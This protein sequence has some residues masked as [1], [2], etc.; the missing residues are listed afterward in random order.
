MRKNKEVYFNETRAYRSCNPLNI[1]WSATTHWQGQTGKDEKGFCQFCGFSFGYQAAV[2]IIRSYRRRHIKRLHTIIETWTSNNADAYIEA[3]VR[4]MSSR[5]SE[6]CAV[7][8][9]TV[10]DLKNRDLIIQL[11]LAMTR[12]EMHANATQTRRMRDYAEMGYDLAI[13]SKGFWG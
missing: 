3:V 8:R 9:N 2:L 11:L 5:Q 13:T 1:K 6:P 10:I 4:F 7:D 12:V